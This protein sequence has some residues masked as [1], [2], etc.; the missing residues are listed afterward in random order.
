MPEKPPRNLIIYHPILF[1]I[2][3]VLVLQAN[4]LDQVRLN[5]GLRA[6][7][8]SLAGGM[9][10]FLLS[11]LVLKE[12]GRAAL[13]SSWA[14]LLFFSYGHIYGLVEDRSL[15]GFIYGRHRFL[16]PLWLAF[17]LAGS[18]WVLKRSQAS[19]SL[20]RLL[21]AT[22]LVLVLFP[23][24]IIGY[25]E[26]RAWRISNQPSVKAAADGGNTGQD[27]TSLPDIYYVILDGYTRADVLRQV[28]NFDNTPFL[29]QLKSMGFVIPDC[30]QSNYAWTAQSLSS[31]F[32]MNYLETYNPRV[33]A[34]DERPDYLAYQGLIMHNPVR[35]KLAGLGYKMV[36]FE[37]DFPFTEVTDADIYIVGNAN[38]LEK[39]K[40][41]WEVSQFEVM[42][43]RTT[44]LRIF[45]EAQDAYLKKLMSKVRTPNEVHYD[46]IRF[47]LDQLGTIPSLVP[48]RK[49][50]FAHLVAPH[51]PYVF[52]PDGQYSDVG[53]PS[54]GY[55][56][57]IAYLNT[58][59]I[60]IVKTILQQSK[61]PPV[62]IIQGDHGWDDKNRMA[63]LNAYYLPNGGSQRIYPTIT[64]V[65]SF[66]IIF[67]QYFGGNYNLLED[68]SYY[69]SETRQ[70][71]FKLVPSNCSV[72]H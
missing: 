72:N 18:W 14:V 53:S 49:F 57:E 36:A 20:Q 17:L 61:T 10:L 43:M 8:Y 68:R 50:V 6:G 1:S 11:R 55:P 23:V 71:D 7:L 12:W 39:M 47:V 56:D 59:M 19:A 33:Q 5:A 41:G 32:H 46:R 28:Y 27:Q 45:G 48:G 70:F 29:D 34:P 3:P 31:T 44:A 16:G 64:P 51:A 63:N 35:E 42:F 2:Y 9:L 54:I 26:V 40:S 65:N 52:K 21:N 38:P 66:R 69:S 25:H 37:T 22:S 60:Q 67:D 4:N 30:A 13:I 58:R 15:A 24:L 62:I